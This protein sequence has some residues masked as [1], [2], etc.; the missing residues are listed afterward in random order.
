[1]RIDDLDG[2]VWLPGDGKANPADL[3]QALA[4]GARNR[5]ARVHEGI[6]VTAVDASGGSR[7]RRALA[8]EGRR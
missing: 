4:K 7:P 1:M 3:T 5:G 8:R 2:A 6:K